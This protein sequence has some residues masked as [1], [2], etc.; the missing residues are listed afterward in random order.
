MGTVCVCVCVC[1][2]VRTRVHANSGPFKRFAD[3]GITITI[4]FIAPVQRKAMHT[5]V[6][7]GDTQRAGGKKQPLNHILPA[8]THGADF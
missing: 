8:P 7:A 1:V 5:T 3:Y 2:C 4:A 6:R